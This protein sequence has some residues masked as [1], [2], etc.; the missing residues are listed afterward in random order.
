[1]IAS[2]RCES[3][4]EVKEM[5]RNFWTVSIGTGG[6]HQRQGSEE[7]GPEHMHPRWDLPAHPLL[8]PTVIQLAADNVVLA[9]LVP[10]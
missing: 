9:F 5:S 2:I 4:L 6:L 8:L 1:M 7:L 3:A 10:H